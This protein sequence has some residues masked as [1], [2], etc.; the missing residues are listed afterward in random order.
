MVDSNFSQS[1]IYSILCKICVYCVVK[2]TNLYCFAKY[3]SGIP[4]YSNSFEKGGL[5]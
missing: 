2:A 1:N 5:F 3:F 4:E